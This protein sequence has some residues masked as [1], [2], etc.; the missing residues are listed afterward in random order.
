MCTT[1]FTR[2]TLKSTQRLTEG[3][4]ELLHLPTT[5][6][7]SKA[8]PRGELKKNLCHQRSDRF[9]R[10]FHDVRLERR[11]VRPGVDVMLT[12]FC[13]F[14]QFS[15]TK[16]AFYLKTNVMVHFMQNFAVFCIKNAI[17]K[18]HFLGKYL[19]S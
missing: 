18:P 9:E 19:K 4:P 12:S 10:A 13:D 5:L 8:V 11:T 6:L 16:L 7:W 1:L 14:H 2:S 15:V 17:L 3:L